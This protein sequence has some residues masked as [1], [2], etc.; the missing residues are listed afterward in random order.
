MAGWERLVTVTPGM[1]LLEAMR[2]MDRANVAQVP[3]VEDGRLVG[4]LSREGV[5][6]ALRLRATDAGI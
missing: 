5:M 6:H 4:V 2:L 3:V 1:T